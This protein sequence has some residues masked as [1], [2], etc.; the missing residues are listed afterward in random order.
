M[1]RPIHKQPM[2]VQRRRLVTQVIVGIDQDGIPNIGHDLRD[3]PLP[4]DAD[5]RTLKRA[6]GVGPDPFDGKVV[7]YRGCQR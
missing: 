1:I 4:V 3:R 7:G 5:G 2:K 6:V